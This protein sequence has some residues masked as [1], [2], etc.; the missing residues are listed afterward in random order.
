MTLEEVINQSPT[1]DFATIKLFV[2]ENPAFDFKDFNTSISL[3]SF[4]ISP[5]NEMD[6]L[7]LQEVINFSKDLDYPDNIL[8]FICEEK[9]TKLNTIKWKEN[10]LIFYSS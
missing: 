5:E 7:N 6:I 3:I 9:E 8:T 10:Q 4:P 1:S 2:N